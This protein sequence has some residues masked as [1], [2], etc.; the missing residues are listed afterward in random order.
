MS[1]SSTTEEANASSTSSTSSGR[2]LDALRAKMKDVNIHA[3]IVPTD[4]PHLSEY[5]PEAYGRRKFLTGFGGSAGT[6]IVTQDAAYL[7]TDS[8]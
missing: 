1:S 6:A 2:K 8:R 3:L 4:D 5:V 7:W